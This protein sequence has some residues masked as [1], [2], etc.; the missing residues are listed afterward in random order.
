M[1]ANFRN[2]RILTT[3]HFSLHSHRACREGGAVAVTHFS[4]FI[5]DL[6]MTDDSEIIEIAELL[7]QADATDDQND[8]KRFFQEHQT[9]IPDESALVVVV[10]MLLSGKPYE[11]L[12]QDTIGS[13]AKAIAREIGAKWEEISPAVLLFEPPK[14]AV[15]TPWP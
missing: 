15:A 9:L 14:L 12:N 2:F 13:R 5:R 11:V 10:M 4:C 8:W 6:A 7:K 1:V 3:Y